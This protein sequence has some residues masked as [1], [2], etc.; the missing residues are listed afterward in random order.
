MTQT[1]SGS[2]CSVTDR[3]KQSYIFVTRS[4]D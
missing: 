4:L 1:Y 3:A 2:H